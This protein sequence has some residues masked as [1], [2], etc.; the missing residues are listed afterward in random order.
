MTFSVSKVPHVIVQAG[1]P[2]TRMQH[3]TWNKPKCLVSV[4]GRPMLYT[5]FDRFPDASFTVIGDYLFEVLEAY[6]AANP[7]PVPVTLVR[8]QGKGTIAGVADALM[9]LPDDKTPFALVWS[10]L[11]VRE[12]PPDPLPAQVG[13]GLSRSFPCRWSLTEAGV[14]VEESSNERGV[15]GFFTFPNRTVLAGLPDRGEFVRWLSERGWRFDTFFID[16][17]VEVGEIPAYES[18]LRGHSWARFFNDVQI[19]EEAVVK[20]P[21]EAS[22]AHLISDE[23]HWYK[24][25]QGLGFERAPKL[26]SENPMTLTRIHGQHP[27]DLAGLPRRRRQRILEDVFAVLDSLHALD[28]QSA[29]A[30]AIRAVYITK[31]QERVA[32]VAKLLPML[33]QP[34]ITVNGRRCRNPFAPGQGAVLDE[35]GAA[36]VANCQAFVPI[37]GDPTFSNMLVDRKDQAW[38]IDPRGSFGKVKVYGDARYDWAKLY[39][40]VAGDYDAFNRRKFTLRVDGDGVTLALDGGGWRDREGLFEARFGPDGMR[41]LWLLH[42]LIWI[43]LCGYVKDDLDSILGSFFNGLW[44]LEESLA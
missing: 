36:L 13:L 12:A 20:K 10:D 26:L 28:R 37:H 2:G 43:S 38:L 17:T 7:P 21:R 15:A 16:G 6:V 35:I 25:V 8:A 19:G 18:V 42:G 31:T 30:E 29:D 5:L 23:I 4:G 1:G 27:F 40:S 32:S 11:M 9:T 34:E 3:L 14:L 22:H 39:Y 44:W 33:D 41:D 24:T